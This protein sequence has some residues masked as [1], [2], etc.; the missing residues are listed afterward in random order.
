MHFDVIIGNPPYQLNT[1][2]G[3]D[4]RK[5]AIP[6]Y[7][8]FVDQAKSLDPQFLIMIIPARWYSGGK[9]LNQFRSDMLADPFIAE[10]H[11][12]PETDMVFPGQN[13]VAGYVIF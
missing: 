4:V 12:Y 1:G 10:I 11:D 3:E 7:H 6:I 8:K 13:I 2:D 9:G 5:D